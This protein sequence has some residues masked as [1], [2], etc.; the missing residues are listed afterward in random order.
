MFRVSG[1]VFFFTL[2]STLKLTS[3]SAT[4]VK[5]ISIGSLKEA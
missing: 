5:D 3:F 4:A 1:V 2:Q